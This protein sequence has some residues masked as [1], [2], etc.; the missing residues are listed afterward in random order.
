MNLLERIVVHHSASLWGTVEEI[1]KWHLEKGWRDIGYNLVIYNGYTEY[2]GK[3]HPELDGRLFVG[4]GLDLDMYIS[5][6]EIGAHTLGYNRTS[7]GICHIG[8][9]EPTPKQL[10]T[11]GLVCKLYKRIVPTV[12]IGGHSDYNNTSCPGWNVKE[13]AKK[14]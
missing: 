1:R 8:K 4:R 6:K 11:L 2:K 10:I 13:W 12:E 14:L 5:P 7:F 3:Y 9:A